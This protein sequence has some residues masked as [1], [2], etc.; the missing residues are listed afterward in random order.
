MASSHSLAFGLHQLSPHPSNDSH[1]KYMSLIVYTGELE[2][3]LSNVTIRALPTFYKALH[4]LWFSEPIVIK[5][6]RETVA[7]STG[8]GE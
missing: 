1:L 6:I 4:P 8:S 2:L 3:A 5:R 7:I